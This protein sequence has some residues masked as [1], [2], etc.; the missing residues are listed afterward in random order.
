MLVASSGKAPEFVHFSAD[1]SPRV[2]VGHSAIPSAG[3]G[4]FLRTPVAAG[5]LVEVEETDTVWTLTELPPDTP[6]VA[7]CCGEGTLHHKHHADFIKTPQGTAWELSI[8]L[9]AFTNHNAD[10]NCDVVPV[11]VHALEST[12]T[13]PLVEGG[14]YALFAA[15]DMDMNTELTIDYALPEAGGIVLEDWK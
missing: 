6:F 12:D 14:K 11:V 15:R 2:R 4:T 9:Q 1:L 13:C 8:S 7:D 5:D 10:P 3:L